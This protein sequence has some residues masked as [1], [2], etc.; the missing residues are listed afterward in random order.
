MISKD[1]KFIYIYFQVIILYNP[2]GSHAK[3]I[4]ASTWAEVAPK[5]VQVGANL[6]HL[7]AKL[8]WGWPEV[9]PMLRPCWIE[10]VHLD[11]F[12]RCC[13][14]IQNAPITTV[15]CTFLVPCSVRKCLL[16]SW[17]CTRSV[18]LCRSLNCHALA[19][20]VRADFWR[21]DPSRVPWH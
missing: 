10:T 17:S 8:G 19:A 21:N 7:G 14:D 16:P 6:R 12:G 1:I 5:W 4:W 2:K 11:A 3:P 20:S 9:E 13:A 18:H 15:L